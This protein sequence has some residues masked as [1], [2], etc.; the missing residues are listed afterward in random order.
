[1]DQDIDSLVVGVRADTAG[2]ARDVGEMRAQLEGPFAASAQKAGIA[3]ENALVK[4]VKTGKLSFADLEAAAL[5]ALG[6][7]AA[8]AIRS[9]IGALFGGSG[10]AGLGG[11]VGGLIGAPGRAI[12]GPVSGGSAYLVGERGPELFVPASSGRIDPSPGS[13]GG[14]VRVGITINA[15][16]GSEPKALQ[17]SSRQVARAVKSA[18]MRV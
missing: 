6:Q 15:P 14:N 7:I 11:I 2:F 5:T 4:A 10:S 1:M 8:S 16:Q 12:G 3:L 9:G 17:Q 13:A 18:L